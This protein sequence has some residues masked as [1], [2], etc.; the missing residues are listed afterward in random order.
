MSAE[1]SSESTTDRAE[2]W[3]DEHTGAEPG[4][5]PA[6]AY[7]DADAP[8]TDAREARIEQEREAA[9]GFATALPT[10]LPMTRG[11]S[12]GLLVGGLVGGI[13]G[14]V[15]LAPLGLVDWVELS[16]GVRIAMFA[17]AGFLGGATAG[18]VYAGGRVPE[19]EGESTDA[20]GTPSAGSTLADG[21]TDEHGRLH[22]QG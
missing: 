8:V 12:Q 13:V 7:R 18:A 2:R 11:Q 16:T 10:A 15:L 4:S 22:H 9:S 5:A 1:R 14:A 19:L 21:A 20:D 6:P 3:V 17:L